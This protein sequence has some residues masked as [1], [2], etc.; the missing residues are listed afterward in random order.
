MDR[1]FA[2]IIEDERDISA[3][4][5]HVLDMSG[6]GTQIAMHGQTAVDILAVSRPDL[7]LLD[8]NLPG[9]PGVKILDMIRKDERL[10]K[11]KVIVT[12]GHADIAAGLPAEADLILLKPVSIDQLSTVAKRYLAMMN[13]GGE[14]PGNASPWDQLTGLY[15]QAFFVNRLDFSLRRAREI[16]RLQFSVISISLDQNGSMKNILRDKRWTAILRETAA[17]LRTIVRPTDTIARFDHDN[18]YVLIEDVANKDIPRQIAA[19]VHAGL[20]R[21][22]AEFEK[23][24]RFP[25]R[26]GL[27][28]CDSH[29]ENIEQIL[30]DAKTANS[31]A[32][33]DREFFY[34]EAEM[35]LRSI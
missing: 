2:L 25:I 1:P 27:I 13:P 22:L 3:L 21:H 4:F 35:T 7:I 14:I 33:T 32:N 24:V 23:E 31:L 18:F 26:V 15:N 9:V 20:S 11:S 34:N 29:Y 16:D 28:L 10:S 12:T 6:F 5:R 30:Q 8:L 19:R 17:T